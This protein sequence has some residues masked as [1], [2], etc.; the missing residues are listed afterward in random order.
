ML[1]WF[2]NGWWIVNYL[3]SFLPFYLLIDLHHTTPTIIKLV[4][5]I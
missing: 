2:C 1:L 4:L 5:P 3:F